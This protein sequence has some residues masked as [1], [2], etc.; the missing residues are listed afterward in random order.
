MRTKNVLVTLILTAIVCLQSSV[1]ANCD[2]CHV[3]L[4]G[5]TNQSVTLSNNQT[6]C[7]KSGAN[8]ANISIEGSNTKICIAEGATLTIGNFTANN[9]GFNF[10]NNGTLNIQNGLNVGGTSSITN[11]GTVN[12]NGNINFNGQLVINNVGTW[13]AKANFDLKRNGSKFINDGVFVGSSQLINDNG[14][15]IIN[16]GR[17]TVNGHINPEGIFTN[18]GFLVARDFINFNSNSTVTNNCTFY[19]YGGFNNIMYLQIMD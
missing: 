8:T 19:S 4:N 3:T 5:G 10:A 9:V 18:N 14:T 1:F 6:L 16:N 2:I 12:A 7:V 13:N 15:E 17:M 11:N